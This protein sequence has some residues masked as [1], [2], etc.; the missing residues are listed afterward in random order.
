VAKVVH[1]PAA[2]PLP[3]S[4]DFLVVTQ[5]GRAR[6]FE[7]FIDA[8]PSLEPKIGPR[9]PPGGPGYVSVE[10][11]IEAAQELA[12][13]HHVPTIYVQHDSLIVR[14]Y[15]PGGAPVKP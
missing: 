4:G 5:I 14:P 13:I 10:K 8:S 15:F 9:V 1:L 12:T 3:D 11:A 6:G 7:Y 2:E